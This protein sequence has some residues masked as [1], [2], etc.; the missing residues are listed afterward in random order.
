MGRDTA[1]RADA[2]GP[3]AAPPPRRGRGRGGQLGLGQQQRG[4]ERAGAHQGGLTGGCCCAALSSAAVLPVGRVLR[5][6]CGAGQWRP[7]SKGW[8]AGADSQLWLA[9]KAV[10]R[11]WC[12]LA[13]R[14]RSCTLHAL[15]APIARSTRCCSVDG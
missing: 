13:G 15:Q 3:R 6:A 2:G 12:L 11:G 1:L 4:A 7:A 14:C 10:A 8:L 9:A 5:A